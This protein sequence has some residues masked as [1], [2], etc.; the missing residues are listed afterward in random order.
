MK[1]Y[2]LFL[3][4]SLSFFTGFAQSTTDKTSNQD[5]AVISTPAAIELPKVKASVPDAKFTK[6]KII[7]SYERVLE[8]GY[9][10]EAMLTKVADYR[11]FDGD[12]IT[13][14]KWYSQLFEYCPEELEAVYFYRYAKSL[15][16]IDQIEKAKEMMAI[17]QIK[18]T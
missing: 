17:Y 4:T 6:I 16:S 13:A 1:K 12:L 7:E 9:I 15:E 3:V 18:K 11:F 10:T 5:V 8:K 14:A 2:A